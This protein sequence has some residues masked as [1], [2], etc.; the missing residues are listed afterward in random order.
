MKSYKII[1]LAKQVPDTRNVGKD[2][3]KADGTVNRAALPAVF[4]PEDMHALEQALRIKDSFPGSTITLVTM[5]P[6]RAAEIIREALYRGADSGL[7]IT[8][9]AF[10][11]SD[12]LATSYTIS[13]ALEKLKP[14]DI[15]LCGRQAI[16][17]DT[18]QVGPQVAEKLN[19][20]QITYTEE[21]E[22]LTTNKI[23]VKRRLE[24]G[25]ETVECPLP[26]LL[27]VHS[28]APEC[29]SRNSKYTMKYKHARTVS[30][31]QDEVKDYEQLLNTRQYLKIA[32]WT[33]S[34]LDADINRLGLN[35]SPTKVKAIQNVVFKAKETVKLTSS[36]ADINFLMKELIDNHTIG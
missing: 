30:E 23:T 29:R 31:L 32:E 27:T 24:R 14:Y 26:V 28:S 17:G 1:V 5:G 15:I 13:L 22:R 3:M 8:D 7:L 34:N 18:A 36:D 20:P 21:I 12:T 9:R 33:V 11:G 2:A 10:A 35:G 4:N 16:D 19:I 6:P 25:V